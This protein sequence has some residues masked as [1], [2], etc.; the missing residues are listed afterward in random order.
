MKSKIFVLL[1]TVMFVSCAKRE[2]YSLKQ[3]SNRYA[4]G[5][6]IEQENDYTKVVVFNP[7][8]NGKILQTY[9]L[10]K[11]DT[12]SIPNDGVKLTI[13]IKR[14]ATTSCTHIGFLKELNK[15]DMVCGVC[16]P[17][18]IYDEYVRERVA[19]GYVKNVG[20]AMMPNVEMIVNSAPEV[21]MV[22][23]YAQGDAATEKLNK[24]GMPVIYNNEWTESHP[25]ARAEWL[26]FTAA[27]FDMLPY[28]DSVFAQI[29]SRYLS[30]CELTK[31]ITDKRT[32]MSGNNFRGTWYMPSGTTYM[33]MLF[34]D[35]GAD[36]FYKNDKSAF[37]LPLNVETVVMNFSNADVWVWSSARSL[38]E[39]ASTDEKHTWFKSYK[40]GQVYNFLARTTPTGGND[41]WESGVVHPELVLQDLIEIIYPDIL[42]TDSLYFSEH[43]Q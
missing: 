35:A 39:L 27:F 31:D 5:F 25:L 7:W 40:T 33:G 9:Y 3:T 10:V 1:A 19:A 23:T 20:D 42:P 22:S 37:S 17:E 43:L 36:Y 13:P 29:E 12:I 32:I 41:F 30:L 11:Y 21:V 24:L 2:T 15:L 16:N 28:A 8:Q 18:I 38:K 14:V 6:S 4:D 34:A 26:R